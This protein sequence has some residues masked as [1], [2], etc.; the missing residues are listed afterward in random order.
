MLV[1]VVAAGSKVVVLELVDL[2]FGD[3]VS[4]GNFISVTL[5]VVALL[6]SRARAAGQQYPGRS[7]P[8]PVRNAGTGLTAIVGLHH[9]R[10]KRTYWFRD[11]RI[12]AHRRLTWLLCP[13]PRFGGLLWHAPEMSASRVP[14]CACP[15]C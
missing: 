7:A 10:Q 4:L 6:V 11:A 3:T 2:V 8:S 5:L 9:D 15:G 12:L 14:G 13:T 1:W